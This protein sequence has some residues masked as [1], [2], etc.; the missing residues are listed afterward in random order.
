[1]SGRHPLQRHGWLWVLLAFL[2][3]KLLLFAGFPE[4][5][6]NYLNP[7]LW[8][9]WDSGHYFAIA[10]QGYE[11]F[12][13]WTKFPTYAPN[14]PALCGNCGWMPGFPLLILL[15][16]GLGMSAAVAA[17]WIVNGTFLLFLSFLWKHVFRPAGTQ[18]ILMLFLTACWPGAVYYQAA[19]PIALFVLMVGMCLTYLQQGR[20]KYAAVCAAG[21][22]LA[23]STGFLLGAVVVPYIVYR[24]KRSLNELLRFAWI[25]V[26]SLLSFALVLGFQWWQTG[27]FGA[28]F[29]TQSKYGHG[30]NSPLK[31]LG[32]IGNRALE[33]PN[34][35]V[36]FT[37]WLTLCI[38]A[39]LLLFLFWYFLKTEKTELK[40][41]LAAYVLCF[42]FLPLSMSQH[43]A[44]Y[45]QAAALAPLIL[46][47][48]PLPRQ[49]NGGVLIACMAIN[50]VL[51]RFFLQDLLP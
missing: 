47:M 41:L 1:M 23:Y 15:F 16:Q 46:F 8:V 29:K 36:R 9:R 6:Q 21:A 22:S 10:Q 14:S 7:D 45:R 42:W 50:P 18:G 26:A 32:F 17:Q 4:L 28:F 39:G 49:T 19:F 48:Q 2:G 25:P 3:H 31:I 27:V 12:P 24:Y 33:H 34:T 20:W 13:C 44:F 51:A 40:L 35:A 5:G 37:D 43:L 11:A 38:T 30:L